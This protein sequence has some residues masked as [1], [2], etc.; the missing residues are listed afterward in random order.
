M[1]SELAIYLRLAPEFGG[2]R[3]GPFQGIEV[4]LGSDAG[5]CDITLAEALGVLPVHVRILRQPDLSLI[6][7]PVERTATVFLWRASARRPTQLEV[8]TAIRP[9]DAFA[10]VTEQGPRFIVEL[11]TLPEQ[12]AGGSG[13]FGSKARKRLSGKALADEGKRQALTQVLTTKIGAEVQ[14]AFTFIKTGTFLQPRYLFVGLM[15]IA[16]FAWGGGMSCKA[17]KWKKNY[18]TTSVRLENCNKSLEFAQTMEGSEKATF[19]QLAARITDSVGLGQALED[20]IVQ[21]AVLEQLT[22]IRSA[23]FGWLLDPKRPE[24]AAFA[25]WR[26]E[27][28]QDEGLDAGFAKAVVWAGVESALGHREWGRKE[29]SLQADV[30]TRGVG[31]L[32]YRQALH[33]G[34]SVQPDALVTGDL[35]GLASNVARRDELLLGTVRAAGGSALPEGFE[36]DVAPFSRGQ[37]GCLFVLGD[38]DRTRVARVIRT[39]GDHLG[40]DA[41]LVPPPESPYGITSRLAKFFAADL[42]DADFRQRDID[43]DFAHAPTGTVLMGLGTRGEWVLR[44]TARTLARSILLPCKVTLEGGQDRQEAEKVVG[45]LPDAIPCLVLDYRMTHG[46]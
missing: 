42:P 19:T 8:A 44:E 7:A 15:L 22:A 35:G 11:D 37:R 14:R 12:A 38:D 28:V 29:D 39:M 9:G 34:L 46:W 21:K 23:D 31:R 2:T 32:T 17:T 41:S 25:T 40:P 3:F 4:V 1:K 5:R 20:E 13:A 33:L 24:A 27:I 6:I 16:G 30:C 43:L 45:P 36:S 26:Q 18:G 10:L